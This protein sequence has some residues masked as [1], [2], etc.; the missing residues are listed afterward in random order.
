MQRTISGS[1]NFPHFLAHSSQTLAQASQ[2][3][4]HRPE[5]VAQK[6]AQVPHSWA[7]SII[8]ITKE[9]SH[10][11]P[12]LVRQ[13]RTV[14]IHIFWHFVYIPQQRVIISIFIISPS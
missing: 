11:L 8:F 9:T 3:V 1:E 14:S 7:H 13:N 2:V 6:P 12:P 10:N 5:P 4:A